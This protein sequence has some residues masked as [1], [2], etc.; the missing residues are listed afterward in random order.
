VSEKRHFTVEECNALIPELE[1]HFSQVMQ[2]R[3]QLRSLYAE[4]EKL[5]EAPSAETIQRTTGPAVLVKTRGKFRGMM[6]ALTEELHAIEETGA[7]VKDLDM[8]LCDFLGEHQGREVWLC[9]Q[10][11]EKRIG[12]WHDLDSGF[13]S[14]QP[15]DGG[16][17]PPRLLH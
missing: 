7:T 1:V 9:W 8:G 14:R 17:M 4:L 12:F 13:S 6:E 15:L 10:Y 11:G 5:G 3:A 16:V 2:L